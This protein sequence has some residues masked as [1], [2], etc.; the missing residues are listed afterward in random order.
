MEPNNEHVDM[1][2]ATAKSS[3]HP[4]H[5]ITVSQRSPVLRMVVGPPGHGPVPRWTPPCKAVIVKEVEDQ[6]QCYAACSSSS[7][8]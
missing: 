6:T 5:A 2:A 8:S 3:Q 1:G 7:R 4:V